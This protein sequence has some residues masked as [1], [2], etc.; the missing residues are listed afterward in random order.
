MVIGFLFLFTQVTPIRHI[1]TPYF[2]LINGQDYF[3]RHFLRKK[4]YPQ[5]SPRPPNN[6]PRKRVTKGSWEGSVKR[7][8]KKKSHSCYSSS[9]RH[10]P[11][12]YS[13]PKDAVFRNKPFTSSISQSLKCLELPFS[14]TSNTH[15]SLLTANQN[16]LGKTSCFQPY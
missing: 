5:Q 14:Q 4:A 11:H 15:S 13:K 12:L 9:L 8:N 16:K 7:S 2:E 1:P 6:T 3:P 10:P